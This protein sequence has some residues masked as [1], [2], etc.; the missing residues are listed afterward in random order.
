MLRIRSLRANS[1]TTRRSS[2]RLGRSVPSR[3]SELAAHVVAQLAVLAAHEGRGVVS[4]GFPDGIPADR[5]ARAI[6]SVRGQ[7]RRAQRLIEIRQT[8]QSVCSGHPGLAP[9]RAR[10]READHEAA[11]AAGAGFRRLRRGGRETAGARKSAVGGGLAE[12]AGR[13][14]THDRAGSSTGWRRLDAGASSLAIW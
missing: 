12:P 7:S 6:P 5:S 4:G 14:R 2:C 9:S 1:E 10:D 8:E 11:V 13:V 3:R